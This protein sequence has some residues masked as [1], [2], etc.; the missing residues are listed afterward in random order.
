M[1][2]IDFLFTLFQSPVQGDISLA[3]APLAVMGI[4][5]GIQLGSGLYKSAKAN[6]ALKELHKQPFPE[7]G[8][9]SE[10][11]KSFERSSERAE[12]GFTA[13]QTAAATQARVRSQNTG[14]KIA[15]DRAP[16]LSQAVQAGLNYTNVAAINQFAAADAVQ[17]SRNIDT[18]DRFVR[19]LQSMSNQNTQAQIQGRLQAEVQLG[20]AGQEGWNALSTIGGTA[21][22]IG[23]YQLGQQGFGGNKTTNP[24]GPG[25]G[26]GGGGP[27]PGF[28]GK[29][30]PGFSGG[31]SPYQG[32]DP[33]NSNGGL[34]ST[35]NIFAQSL[36]NKQSNTK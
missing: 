17:M 11:M 6:K 14:T 21:A 13:E 33:Y 3:L 29:F 23:A 20:K 12:R 34:N 18:N 10:F 24:G 27:G 15:L 30:G 35:A 7:L 26:L 25:P 16:G 19:E 28:G 4:G 5:M 31:I 32:Y 8:P 9:N 22:G 36:Y 2:F 1:A